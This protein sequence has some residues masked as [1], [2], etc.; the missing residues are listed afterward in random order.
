MSLEH[1]INVTIFW[2]QR[3]VTLVSLKVPSGNWLAREFNQQV[4]TFPSF[5]C[6]LLGVEK[7][8]FP[9]F[10]LF[11]L[12]SRGRGGDG[13]YRI[14]G[15]TFFLRKITTFRYFF[16]LLPISHTWLPLLHFLHF[17]HQHLFGKKKS[18]YPTLVKAPIQHAHNIHSTYQSACMHVHMRQECHI[19]TWKK[20][21]PQRNFL[22]T[23]LLLAF[24]KNT[25]LVVMKAERKR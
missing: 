17:C 25:M 1:H 6:S 12:F 20:K 15:K 23:A 13:F 9:L 4:L 19:I 8:F 3:P 11:L 14:Y 18:L 2:S 5:L 16:S 22:S 21:K 10:T 7:V 24:G